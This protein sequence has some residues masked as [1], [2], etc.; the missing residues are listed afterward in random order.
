ML[1]YVTLCYSIVYTILYY[2]IPNYNGGP[3][4]WWTC[5]AVSAPKMFVL[6]TVPQKGNP[7]RGIR[8][9]NYLIVTFES[10]SSQTCCL[11]LDTPSG[12][13]EY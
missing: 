8:Q 1:C 2:T 9:T 11:L 6:N 12:D 3:S 4:A 7:K 13:I 5:A 10:R